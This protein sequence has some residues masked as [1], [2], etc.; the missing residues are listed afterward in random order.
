MISKIPNLCN[1]KIEELDPQEMIPLLF[2][3]KVTTERIENLLE[4]NK[5]NIFIKK[6]DLQDIIDDADN[7]SKLAEEGFFP[8][9]IIDLEG[10]ED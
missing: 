1:V 10:V 5:N 2:I 6:S 9:K 4:K 3:I 8:K 7:F